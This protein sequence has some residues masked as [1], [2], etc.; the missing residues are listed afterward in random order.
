MAEFAVEMQN[1]VKQFPSP[2]GG[3][4]TAV[5]HVTL[6]IRHGEFFSLLGPSGCGK[7]WVVPLLSS[8]L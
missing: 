4:V 5:D 1:V 3:E 8:V 7:R 6:R 2:E